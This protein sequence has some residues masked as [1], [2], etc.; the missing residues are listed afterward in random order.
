MVL[1]ALLGL[2]AGCH[3]PKEAFPEAHPEAWT[4]T[5]VETLLGGDDPLEPW[6]R[7]MFSCTDFLMNYVADPLGRV[8]CSIFPRPFIEHFHNVCV[9][10][11]FPARAVSCLL[12]AEWRGAGDE[13]LR[14]LIMIHLTLFTPVTQVY[15]RDSM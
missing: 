11:E 12:R 6:N 2:C 5:E 13:T 4:P 1:G 7:A 8:Y 14:F 10:L 3:H 9:N 15:T